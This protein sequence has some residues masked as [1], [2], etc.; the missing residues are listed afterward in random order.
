[1]TKILTKDDRAII[2]NSARDLFKAGLE[3]QAFK[4][5]QIDDWMSAGV[6][7]DIFAAITRRE[8]KARAERDELHANQA[9]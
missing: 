5:A 7:F 3:Q 1:M 6:T 8:L 9:G 4:L 2:A